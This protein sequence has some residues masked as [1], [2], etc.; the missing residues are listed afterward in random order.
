[1]SYGMQNGLTITV[2]LRIDGQYVRQFYN[3]LLR[4]Y[5][6]TAVNLMHMA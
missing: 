4:V 5:Q 3:H 1:M 2:H 6:I